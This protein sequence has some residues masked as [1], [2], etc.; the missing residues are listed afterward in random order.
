MPDLRGLFLRGY[1]SQT[2]AQNNGTTVGISSTLHQSGA[3]GTTQGDAARRVTA[4]HQSG[5]M[6]GIWRGASYGLWHGAMS[7][8]Y[9]ASYVPTGN[10]PEG[11]YN[12]ATG[13]D[14]DSAFVSPTATENR[15]VNVAVR[16]LVRA[17]P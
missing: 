3:L 9:G 13:F 8:I 6:L 16:Y 1:G 10:D 2:Y 17:L 7:P 11:G 15:P 5:S 4:S 12:Q 14:F